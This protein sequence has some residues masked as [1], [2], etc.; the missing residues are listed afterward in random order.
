MT[1]VLTITNALMR[2]DIAIRLKNFPHDQYLYVGGFM[3]SIALFAGTVVLLEILVS[4]RRYR[5]LLLPWLATFLACLITMTTWGRGVLLANSPANL[6]DTVLPMLMGIV[7]VCM[8]AI[9]SPRVLLQHKPVDDSIGALPAQS[10]TH[11]AYWFLFS[12]A[13]SLLAVFL[14]LNR[15]SLTHP[16]SDFG[17]DLQPLAEQYMGWMWNDVRGASFGTVLSLVSAFVLLRRPK[18][19]LG[20]SIGLTVIPVVVFTLVSVQADHQR[21]I[22]NDFIFAQAQK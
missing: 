8:F 2:D 9:L 13:H 6:W 3:R 4:W 5:W 12:T 10:F 15:I 14:V 21:K 22:T 18:S 17:V 1:L 20:W 7:E 19:L 16:T 11:W